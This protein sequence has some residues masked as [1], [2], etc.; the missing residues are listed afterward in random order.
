[1]T[2]A[3]HKANLSLEE[4]NVYD[5]EGRSLPVKINQNSWLTAY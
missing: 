5:N 1:M 2:V 3:I 4:G